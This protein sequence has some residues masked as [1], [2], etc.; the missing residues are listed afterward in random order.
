M[1]CPCPLVSLSPLQARYTCREES[2]RLNCDTSVTT[3]NANSLIQFTNSFTGFCCSVPINI[4]FSNGSSLA[5][6]QPAFTDSSFHFQC[7]YY[8][9]YT[10]WPMP[11]QETV[12][13]VPGSHQFPSIAEMWFVSPLKL[14]RVIRP[15]NETERVGPIHSG[16]GNVHNYDQ[17]GVY[18]KA[19]I[20]CLRRKMIFLL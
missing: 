6:P 9:C 17:Q 11:A 14:L 5:F 7:F 2:H 8:Y 13:H 18:C 12:Y 20:V 3:Y 4:T 19:G 1:V 16:S 15:P 10:G